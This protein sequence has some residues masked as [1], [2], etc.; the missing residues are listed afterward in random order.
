MHHNRITDLKSPSGQLRSRGNA[1][2]RP[3]A[4]SLHLYD[5]CRNYILLADVLHLPEVE[6]SQILPRKL[7]RFARDACIIVQSWM[8]SEIARLEGGDHAE[9]FPSAGDAGGR[10]G[11]TR[12]VGT[13]V[14]VW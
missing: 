7:V 2:Q 13:A 11:L 8:Y 9:H 1:A 4:L 3:S 6:S 10:S 12:S 5:P 14:A